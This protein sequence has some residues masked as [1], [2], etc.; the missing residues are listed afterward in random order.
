MDGTLYC[1][2]SVRCSDVSTHSERSIVVVVPALHIRPH[3]TRLF[4][5]ALLYDGPAQVKQVDLLSG[6]YFPIP[7]CSVQP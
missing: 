3:P 7:G 6:E 2:S 5:Q 4:S 1:T